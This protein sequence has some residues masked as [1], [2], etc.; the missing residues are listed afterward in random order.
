MDILRSIGKQSGES[1]K[2]VSWI[3]VAGGIL[4]VCNSWR[5]IKSVKKQLLTLALCAMLM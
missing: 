4:Q 1:I 5:A 3:V 2:S